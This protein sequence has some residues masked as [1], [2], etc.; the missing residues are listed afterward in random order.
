ERE[1]VRGRAR[2]ESLALH[3]RL[4]A[5]RGQLRKMVCRGCI[6]LFTSAVETLPQR[7]RNVGALLVERLPLGAQLLHVE[8]KLRRFQRRADQL[9]GAL[10]Q[11]NARGMLAEALPTL[12]LA[13]LLRQTTEALHGWLRQQAGSGFQGARG[14]R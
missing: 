8:R 12:E 1:C 2:D 3:A 5:L 14:I 4:F 11:L 6:G 7:L 9:L 13:Q 10:T